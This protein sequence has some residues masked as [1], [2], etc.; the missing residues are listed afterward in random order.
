M[1]MRCGGRLRVERGGAS[2]L[3]EQE[4]TGERRNEK[5]C[6]KPEYKIRRKYV[7]GIIT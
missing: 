5:L 2:D 1:A 4:G 6:R 3:Q 7:T